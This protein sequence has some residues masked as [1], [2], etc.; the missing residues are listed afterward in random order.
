ML[1]RAWGLTPAHLRNLADE[2]TGQPVTIL[3]T[4]GDASGRSVVVIGRVESVTGRVVTL[5]G[6]LECRCSD[7]SRFPV[8]GQTVRVG[9][10][11]WFPDAEIPTLLD[12]TVFRR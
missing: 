4:V 5:A 12:C 8:V 10:V 1:A 6:P 2:L 3:G 11:L 9:G 7:A